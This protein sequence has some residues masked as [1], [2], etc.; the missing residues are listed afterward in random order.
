MQSGWAPLSRLLWGLLCSL[1]WPMV[2]CAPSICTCKVRLSLYQFSADLFC[3]T[4]ELAD[5]F[6]AIQYEVCSSK[7]SA[8]LSWGHRRCALTS[9]SQR[10]TIVP[11]SDSETYEGCRAFFAMCTVA[12]PAASCDLLVSWSVVH[13]PRLAVQ[14]AV[15]GQ[16]DLHLH[17]KVV[18]Q[19]VKLLWDTVIMLSGQ[20]GGLS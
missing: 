20:I 18:E 1:Q 15:H 9:G 12:Q 2:Q 17:N 7:H 11:D 14:F 13:V 3:T 4:V 10:F 16:E 5:A 19:Q 6:Q 8:S